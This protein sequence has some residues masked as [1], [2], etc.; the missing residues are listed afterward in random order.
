MNPVL[1]ARAG[2]LCALLLLSAQ[3]RA[4]DPGDPGRD[5]RLADSPDSACDRNHLTSWFGVIT[6][7][8]QTADQTWLEIHTDYDTVEQITLDHAG[9]ADA[10]DYFQLWEQ[11]FEPPDWAL[12][13]Q[14]PGV[15]K[16]GVRAVIWVCND[17][18]T[19]PLVDWQPPNDGS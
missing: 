4:V 2:I 6:G 19:P 1:G 13:R 15:L 3:V 7:Y 9:R 11:P 10:A 8:R 5:G 16:E 12:I 14:S 18:A 17:G